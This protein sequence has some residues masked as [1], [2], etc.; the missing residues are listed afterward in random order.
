MPVGP[1]WALLGPFGPFWAL[2]GHG[3]RAFVLSEP[4]S[5]QTNTEH[6]SQRCR[7]FS[8]SCP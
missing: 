8:R 2:L 7:V 1:L 3:H 6:R 5:L 4:N